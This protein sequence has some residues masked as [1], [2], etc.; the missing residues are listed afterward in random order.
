[1]GLT[2][3][4][5][6]GNESWL[7]D[8][9]ISKERW[10]E[11]M[12]TCEKGIH[13]IIYDSIDSKGINIDKRRVILFAGSKTANTTE[14][15]AL[16]MFILEFAFSM[17]REPLSHIASLLGHIKERMKRKRTTDDGDDDWVDVMLKGVG[18]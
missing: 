6:S 2:K 8:L 1:M 17:S 14:C 7:E 11:L 12:E 13:D 10:D 3:L 16:S 18:L 4:Y 9:G 15:C 5:S